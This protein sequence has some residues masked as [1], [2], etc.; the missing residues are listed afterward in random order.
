M[1]RRDFLKY[2]S[3]VVPA[4]AA[5]GTIGTFTNKILAADK[6]HLF[7]GKNGVFSLSVIT[8]QPSRSIHLIEQAIR[9]SGFGNNDLEFSEYRLEGRHIGDIAYVNS[10]KLIDYHK[11]TDEFSDLLKESANSLSLP[12]SLDNPVL[13]RFASQQALTLPGFVNIFRGD[14]I[15]KQMPLDKDID[16]YR[17]EGLKGHVDL[18]IKNKSVKIIS[19]T[20]RHKTCMTMAPISKPGDN[21]IC[22]PNQIN[23]A[24]AGK[25]LH[26]I[27]SITF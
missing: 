26:G 10:N 2:S 3:L 22:I 25:N 6:S 21:L 19:S 7:S 13:L 1:K 5:M 4:A 20:C 15:I 18:S 11:G 14:T 23:V 9:N 16:H 27:D 24:I 12:K 17:V 8:D